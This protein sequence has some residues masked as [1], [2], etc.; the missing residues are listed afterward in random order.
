MGGGANLCFLVGGRV[1]FLIDNFYMHIY[2]N[3]E[4]ACFQI[5][6]NLQALHNLC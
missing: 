1:G 6:G 4:V 5:S 3:F 2:F